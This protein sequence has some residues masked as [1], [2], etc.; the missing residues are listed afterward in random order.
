MSDLVYDSIH[1]HI[2]MLEHIE[3]SVDLVKD[4]DDLLTYTI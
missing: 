3:H 2:H 4:D 1:I